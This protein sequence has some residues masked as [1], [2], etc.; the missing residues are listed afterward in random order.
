MY[1][2]DVFFQFF[3]NTVVCYPSRKYQ[4][5]KTSWIQYDDFRFRFFFDD[6]ILNSDPYTSIFQHV[7]HTFM[8]F[9]SCDIDKAFLWSISTVIYNYSLDIIISKIFPFWPIYKLLSMSVASVVFQ[10]SIKI[11]KRMLQYLKKHWRVVYVPLPTAIG[12]F[13]HQYECSFLLRYNKW[14]A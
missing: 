7:S 14:F 5:S 12:V 3:N 4:I 9:W 8:H 13:I 1:I 6:K 10:S 2:W 11:L